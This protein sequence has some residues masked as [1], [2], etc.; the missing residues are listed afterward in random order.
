MTGNSRVLVVGVLLIV[1]IVAAVGLY[2]WQGRNRTPPLPEP[3][4]VHVPDAI[5]VEDVAVQSDDFDVELRAMRGT[6]CR[7]D[8][9]V[10]VEYRSLGESRQLIIGGRLDGDGGEI[11][12]I[13]RVQRPPVDVDGID[14]VTINV[15]RVYAADEP[16]ERTIN[17]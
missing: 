2:F 13:G 8:V 5:P 15:L 4:Q 16:I 3:K 17:D 10:K 1:A 11:M 12:R 14:R 9:Q 7:A 6:G